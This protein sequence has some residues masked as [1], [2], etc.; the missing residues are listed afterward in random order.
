M[1][2][3]QVHLLRFNSSDPVDQ[4]KNRLKKLFKVA[5]FDS[6]VQTGDI[7]AIKIHFGEKGNVTHVPASYTEPV[8]R[9]IKAVVRVHS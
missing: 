6:V 4:V 9:M 2:D 1:P 7:T 8:V 5:G 3:S